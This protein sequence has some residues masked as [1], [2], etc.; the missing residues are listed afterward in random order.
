M[1]YSLHVP[2]FDTSIGIAGGL[3]AGETT[4]DRQLAG[5]R[6]NVREGSRVGL[7]SETAKLHPPR[8]GGVCVQP[9]RPT[10]RLASITRARHVAASVAIRGQAVVIPHD[11]VT[12]APKI[13]IGES[14]DAL[15]EKSTGRR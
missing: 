3:A 2:I 1:L 9:I 4:L 5:V 13:R 11:I 15:D 7:V 8:T 6:T 10:T 12:I 14:G